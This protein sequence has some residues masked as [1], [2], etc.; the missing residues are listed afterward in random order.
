MKGLFFICVVILLSCSSQRA[1]DTN[2]EIIINDDQ[3]Y[4]YDLKNGIYTIFYM[5]KPPSEIKFTSSKEEKNKII[6]S[7]YTLK[8]DEITDIDKITGNIYIED[9]CTTMPKSFTRLHIKTN[10]LLQEIQIDEDCND[11]Y[12]SNYIRANRIKRFLRIIRNILQSKPQ[13]KNAPE[14]DIWYM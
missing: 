1:K 9:N 14:S 8:I 13:I 3:S 11:F 4:K 6:D 5:S 7:Y 12:L 2:I 10:Y